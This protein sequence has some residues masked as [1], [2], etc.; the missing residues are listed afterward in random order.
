MYQASYLLT[1]SRR[2]ASEQGRSGPVDI[3]KAFHL[4][5]GTSTGGLVATALAA[6]VS[7]EAVVELYRL[8]GKRIFPLQLARSVPLVGTLVR[9][10]GVGTK[11]GE[12]AL[13]DALEH[14]FKDRTIGQLFAAREIA[15]L[16]PAIDLNRYSAVIFKTKHLHRSNGRDDLRTLVEICMATTAAPVLR[17]MAELTEPNGVDAKVVYVDGGL[18]ANN[19]AVHAWVEA[20]EILRQRGEPDRPIQLFTLGNLPAQ[21]GEEKLSWMP[22]RLWLSRAALGWLGGLRALSASMSAQSVGYDYMA[23]KLAE[24]QTGRSGVSNF[25]RRLPSQCPSLELQRYLLNM[26]DAR[27]VVLNALA[28]QATSDVDYFW[29]Q[30]MHDTELQ[31]LHDAIAAA[32][33]LPKLTLAHV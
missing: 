21:G 6:G 27:E 18:W 24:L 26:D 12:Q 3:G 13:R 22:R 33:E 10:L 17:M 29:A 15:L 23:R 30:R 19:P 31:S 5:A 4:V 7:M 11:R 25:A 9:L 32:P 2:V 1:L 14:T 28:R 20:N 8:H 16:I